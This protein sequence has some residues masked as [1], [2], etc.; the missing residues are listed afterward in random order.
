MVEWTGLKDYRESQKPS[1]GCNCNNYIQWLKEILPYLMNL[2]LVSG[3]CFLIDAEDKPEK[4]NQNNQQQRDCA[5]VH[6]LPV[7]LCLKYTG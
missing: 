1:C 6:C 5:Y 2:M 3:L 4:G 7:K